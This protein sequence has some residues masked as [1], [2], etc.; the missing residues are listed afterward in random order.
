MPFVFVS[1][2]VA[3]FSFVVAFFYSQVYYLSYDPTTSHPYLAISKT[4]IIVMMIIATVLSV[5]SLAT[6]II[7]LALSK[8][9]PT[10]KKAMVI[11]T[12]VLS[13]FSLVASIAYYS[14]YAYRNIYAPMTISFTCSNND[15]NRTI[16]TPIHNQTYNITDWKDVYSQMIIS[17]D[18]Y[19]DVEYAFTDSYYGCATDFYNNS[20]SR[21]HF[22]VRAMLNDKY[23]DHALDRVTVMIVTRHNYEDVVYLFSNGRQGKNINTEFFG[24]VLGSETYL[25]LTEKQC[26]VADLADPKTV[27]NGERVFLYVCFFFE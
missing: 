26:N 27:A 20:G 9:N 22:E 24:D 2:G 14:V 15:L 1:F 17:V 19:N 8:K 18:Q 4:A 5:F 12:T 11:V 3:I 10:R 13:C 21:V 23:L 6:A 25:P 7:L 16:K